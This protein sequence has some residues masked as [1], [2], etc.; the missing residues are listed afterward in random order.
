MN[1]PS[2]PKWLWWLAVPL[3]VLLVIAVAVL[4]IDEPLRAYAERELNQRFRLISCT[5]GIL[6]Y[7]RS[8]CPWIRTLT[9]SQKITLIRRWRTISKIQGS[10]QWSA[11]FSGR[12]VTD[13]VIDHPVIH[14]TR[15]QAAKEL[16]ASP[17][18]Q[19]SW[20]EVLF[21]MQEVQIN[22][23]RITNGEI[24]YRENAATKP[25]HITELNV[26]AENIRNV[27]SAPAQYPSHI[28]IEMVVFE[29]GA[30]RPRRP[31]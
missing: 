26:W 7:I 16:E 17:E 28:Q 22:E 14:F 12:I 10:L 6:T 30:L 20:Q 3:G 5:L 11:M 19:Q 13:Q 31:G 27:R 21:A 9:V 25:L 1:V 29:Q 18:H 23:V 8:V 24:T 2:I 15:P 4:F